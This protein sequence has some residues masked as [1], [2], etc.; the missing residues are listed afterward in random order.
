MQVFYTKYQNGK[1]IKTDYQ[2]AMTWYHNAADAGSIDGKNNI[3]SMYETGKGVKKDLRK[4]LEW[5][6]KADETIDST[7]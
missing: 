4:A 2:K 5:H 7:K 1:G 6:Q 3:A